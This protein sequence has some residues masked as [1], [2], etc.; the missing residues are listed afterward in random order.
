MR[1]SL[2]PVPEYM[3][4]TV[5]EA[6]K[7]ACVSR[8]SEIFVYMSESNLITAQQDA[9][10]SVYYISVGSSTCFEC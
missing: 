2:R 4:L 6:F 1:I 9:T 8:D 10:Y 5:K 3:G 7:I